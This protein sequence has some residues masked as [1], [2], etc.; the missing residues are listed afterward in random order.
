[1][2]TS[3]SSHTSMTSPAPGTGAG[4]GAVGLSRSPPWLPLG[5]PKQQTGHPGCLQPVWAPLGK[6]PNSW[7]FGGTFEELLHF[8]KVTQAKEEVLWFLTCSQNSQQSDIKAKYKI[9]FKEVVW[10]KGLFLHEFIGGDLYST[11]NICSA[12]PGAVRTSL[13]C[14]R[15]WVSGGSVNFGEVLLL[16][17]LGLSPRCERLGRHLDDFIFLFYLSFD[18]TNFCFWL[19]FLYTF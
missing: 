9:W 19:L 11:I 3:A 14:R 10:S 13:L 7:F 2:V 17:M 18:L 16:L 12:W 8:L 4:A 6:F 1:M 15:I 5:S